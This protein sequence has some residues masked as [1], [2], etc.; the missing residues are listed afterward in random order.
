MLGAPRHRTCQR[1][2][3]G[4]LHVEASRRH[5]PHRV[6]ELAVRSVLHEIAR[7]PRFQQGDEI[8]VLGVHRE[9]EHSRGR[10]TRHKLLRRGQAIHLRH[11]EIEHGD[12]WSEPLDQRDGVAPIR[13]FPDDFDVLRNAEQCLEAGAH[14][15][16]IVGEDDANDVWRGS[17]HATLSVVA[18]AWPRSGARRCVCGLR[19][20]TSRPPAPSPSR[21]CRVRS[22]R[23]EECGNGRPRSRD[24]YS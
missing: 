24:C 6:G 17:G 22:R 11:V 8:L 12:V 23:A 16:M 10:R 3:G 7:R 5:G 19:H 4:R 14:D 2:R 13:R 21:T 15:E 18:R 1:E 9:D 20:L